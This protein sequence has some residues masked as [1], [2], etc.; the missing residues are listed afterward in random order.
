MTETTGQAWTSNLQE[1]WL[2]VQWPISWMSILPGIGSWNQCSQLTGLDTVWNSSFQGLW[3]Y[4]ESPRQP[5]G[6][7]FSTSWPVSHL[8]Y[9]WSWDS[10]FGITDTALAWIRS[11][12][13]DCSQKVAVGKAKSD[14]VTLAFG[15]PQGSIPGPILFTLYTS[16][17][18]QIC[19]RHGITH[20]FYADD[21]QIY[22]A[23]KLRKE[24]KRTVL[25]D[26]KTV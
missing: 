16:P 4:A 3:W 13:G 1:I 10:N 6:H 7:V 15:V 22:L 17:L 23:F 14:P 26:L 2:N 25:E 24:T 21:Q 9:G 12:L 18:G 11:Y 19:T 20:H 5:R 8:W